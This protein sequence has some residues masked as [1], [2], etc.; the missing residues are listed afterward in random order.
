[1]QKENANGVSSAGLFYLLRGAGVCMRT[2]R[3]AFLDFLPTTRGDNLLLNNVREGLGAERKLVCSD[4]LGWKASL[5]SVSR[6]VYV[7]VVV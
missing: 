5:G 1:M 2:R 7:W 4:A 6:A 3:D